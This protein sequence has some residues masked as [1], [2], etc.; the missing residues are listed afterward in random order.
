MRF[1]IESSQREGVRFVAVSGELDVATAPLLVER[2][3]EAEAGAER[4]IVLDL[5][6]VVFMDSTGLHVILQAHR[7]SQQNGNRLRLTKGSDQ[8]QRLFDLAGALDRLPF[9]T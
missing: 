1:D 4:L 6:D 3:T 5:T 2:L 9:L 7:R 8:V